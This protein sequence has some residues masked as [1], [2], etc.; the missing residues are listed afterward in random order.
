MTRVP[1]LA[2]LAGLAAS[3]LV[4]VLAVGQSEPRAGPALEVSAARG[5]VAVT[6]SRAGRAIL[7]I[8]RMAPGRS[9]SGSIV[10]ANRGRR[11]AAVVLA[12][13]R[14]V[15]QRAPLSRALVLTIAER[16]RRRIASRLLV[17][18]RPVRLRTLRAGARRSYRF[19]VRLPAGIGD[20]YQGARTTVRFAWKVSA[21]AGR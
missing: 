19:T 9:V 16:G 11:P 20:R 10:I 2:P 5:R 13:S 21:G 4:V 1:G 17:V 12:Q 18:R 6:N 3:A 7:K 8:D 14:P 15:D